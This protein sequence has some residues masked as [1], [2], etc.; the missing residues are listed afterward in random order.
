MYVASG[1]GW[2][3]VMLKCEKGKKKTSRFNAYTDYRT[4]NRNH[5]LLRHF[6]YFS[7]SKNKIARADMP[8]ESGWR[9]AGFPR[10]F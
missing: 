4:M 1:F 8:P 3:G 6:F 9:T 7:L 10:L 5:S 2:K